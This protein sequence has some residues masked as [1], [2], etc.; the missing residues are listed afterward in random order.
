MLAKLITLPMASA[1][2]SAS[3]QPPLLRIEGRGEEHEKDRKERDHGSRPSAS[4]QAK[5][6]IVIPA[7]CR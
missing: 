4:S 1:M 2:P 5:R 7:S 6:T 3:S